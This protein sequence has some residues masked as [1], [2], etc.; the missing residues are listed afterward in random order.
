MP[1]FLFAAAENEAEIIRMV[2][3]EL[4]LKARCLNVICKY[5]IEVP[6]HVEKL[7]RS[8]EHSVI[9]ENLDSYV[10]HRV[11]KVIA[12]FVRVS[13]YNC[14][15][16]KVLVNF[17]RSYLLND[18]CLFR[19]EL[20]SI[21]PEILRYACTAS[22]SWRL[23]KSFPVRSGHAFALVS[24][25]WAES[26][27]VCLFDISLFPSEDLEEIRIKQRKEREKK[28]KGVLDILRRK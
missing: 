12:D 26:M 1:L 25:P 14:V 20:L 22:F 7:V 3:Q 15:D 10:E 19:S 5:E 18:V 27:R 24:M 2:P 4:S 21:S 11:H 17:F 28:K 13:H 16:C 6:P 23:G 9:E 8:L